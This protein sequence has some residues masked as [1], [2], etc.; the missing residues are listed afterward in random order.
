MNLD[1]NQMAVVK[2]IV[3]ESVESTLALF[4]T[5]DVAAKIQAFLAEMTLLTPFYMT[6]S[7]EGLRKTIDR[8]FSDPTAR[9]FMLTF[10]TAFHVR[11]GDQNAQYN[12]MLDTLAWGMSVIPVNST[13]DLA[14]NAI[15]AQLLQR[16]PTYEDVLMQLRSNKWLVALTLLTT[17]YRL[18]IT[19]RETEGRSRRGS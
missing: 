17:F 8:V 2:A 9:D 1:H 18:P 6:F 7:G 15:P 5:E 13:V 14:L 12:A 10:T 19:K 3:E 16:L 11:F 4:P